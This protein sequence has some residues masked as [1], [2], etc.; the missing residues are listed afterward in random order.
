MGASTERATATSVEAAGGSDVV[1]A[2]RR[3]AGR[4]AT[5]AA[6]ARVSLA[7]TRRTGL[8][9]SDAGDRSGRSI[10]GAARLASEAVTAPRDSVSWGAAAA[11]ELD[12]TAR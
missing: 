8:T 3:G 4:S 11:G 9:A 12:L 5:G 10:S 6:A 1:G 7:T 2:G